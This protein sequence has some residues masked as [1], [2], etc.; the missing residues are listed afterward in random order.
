MFSLLGLHVFPFWGFM[1]S[2]FGFHVFP[3]MALAEPL[4]LTPCCTEPQD[5]GDTGRANGQ[6]AYSL[7]L[8]VFPRGVSCLPYV[9]LG[10]KDV[11]NSYRNAGHGMLLQLTVP[12]IT[13]ARRTPPEK[14]VRLDDGAVFQI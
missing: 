12:H 8:H 7:M 3:F 14:E 5:K 13:C 11:D 2:L 1:F 10:D 6:W 9:D 4:C